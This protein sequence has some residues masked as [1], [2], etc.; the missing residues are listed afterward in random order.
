MRLV[1][2]HMAMGTLRMAASFCVRK[3]LPAPE[4][5]TSTMFDLSKGSSVCQIHPFSFQTNRSGE[6]FEL[7]GSGHVVE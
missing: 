6:L 5:P 2:S 3:V 1:Q 7:F 4:G